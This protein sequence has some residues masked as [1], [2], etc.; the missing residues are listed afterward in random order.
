MLNSFELANSSKKTKE[1]SKY[2]KPAFQHMLD[3]TNPRL[4]D[5][6]QA[7]LMTRVRPILNDF[8]LTL[9]TYDEDKM[10]ENLTAADTLIRSDHNIEDI[11]PA[12]VDSMTDWQKF[13]R[14]ADKVKH[15]LAAAIFGA[16]DK[17]GFFF[18]DSTTESKLKII[19]SF[20]VEKVLED[21]LEHFNNPGFQSYGMI[22]YERGGSPLDAVFS[23]QAALRA[24]I[25]K[26]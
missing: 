15:S 4:T 3:C 23:Q 13:M 5:D 21:A 12:P 11:K 2:T 18:S 26:P 14:I 19:E 22:Q 8:F 16:L 1:D 10:L 17:N 9:D 24:K 25:D 20:S 7:R 6:E